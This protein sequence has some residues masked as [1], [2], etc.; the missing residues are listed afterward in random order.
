MCVLRG[1]AVGLR[2]G[3]QGKEFESWPRKE[4]RGLG[5]TP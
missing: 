1:R 4:L 3:Y 5:K 2:K